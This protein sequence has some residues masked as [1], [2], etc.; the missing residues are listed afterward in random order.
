MQL[1]NYVGTHR[2]PPEPTT[3]SPG[4]KAPVREWV[5]DAFTVIVR[6]LSPVVAPGTIGI[7][8]RIPEPEAPEADDE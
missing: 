7:T 6:T 8:T 3:E 4:L 1:R 5:R 2:R